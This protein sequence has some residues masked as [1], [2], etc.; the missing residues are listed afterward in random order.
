[1]PIPPA[2]QIRLSLDAAD[3]SRLDQETL[4]AQ[5]K[6]M[7]LS[8]SEI[9]PESLKQY[10]AEVES[11]LQIGQVQSYAILAP[12]GTVAPHTMPRALAARRMLNATE[13]MRSAPVGSVAAAVGVLEEA[14]IGNWTENDSAQGYSPNLQVIQYK[15]HFDWLMSQSG[16]NAFPGIVDNPPAYTGN[17][18]NAAA[19]QKLFIN[20]G[21]TASSTVVKGIDQNTMTAV[22]SNAIQP[23][24][25]ATLSNYDQPGS[26]AIMLVENY[27]TS[28]G[29]ADAVG[30]VSVDWRLQIS[31][32]QRK[33]KDGGDTHPTVLTIS[34]RSV[35]YSDVNLLCSHYNAVLKQFGI[36]PSQAPSCRSF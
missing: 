12:A 24:A 18:D 7:G 17:Y 34:A 16:S 36:D 10:I 30:V 9:T 1:M 4:Q 25:D 35:L 28:T 19:I 33:T 31:D 21:V 5:L 29:Y 14:A 23:L 3:P 26:R 8:C 22:F 13:I 11:Q 27:N 32:Y 20:V 6:D 15:D 2:S